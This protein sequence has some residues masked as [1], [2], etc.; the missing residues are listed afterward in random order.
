MT[1][2]TEHIVPVSGGKD[3]VAAMLTAIKRAEKRDMRL[4]FQHSVT[5]NDHRITLEYLDYLEDALGITID[6]IAADFTAEFAR[7]RETIEAEWSKE[8]R[9]KEHTAACK[10]RREAMRPADWRAACDCPVRISPPVPREIIERAK[11][12][13]QPSG[14]RFLD[15]CMIKGRFPSRT[16]QFCT[17]ELKVLP[18]NAVAHPIVEAGG[19]VIIWSGER[20]AESP[21]R[22]KKPPIQRI[23]WP[24]PGGS[25]VL[26][27]PLFHWQAGQCFALAKRWGI[28]PNPLY[29]IGFKRVGCFPCINCEKQELARIDQFYHEEIDRLREWEIIVALVSRRGAATFF[30]APMVPGDPDDLT[31]AQIDKAVAWAKTSRGGK[32]FD[33]LQAIWRN[34]ADEEGAMCESAYGLCE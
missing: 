9:R 14:N 34:Q 16:A 33:M 7:R 11:L 13:L 10:E 22:A 2:E 28:K 1:P 4:R 23:R 17:E 15:L 32:Q 26:Y 20:A 25:L 31:R 21:K 27:R 18:S 19:N 3:S 8:K 5:D 30:P 6:R 12:L 29:L 24:E